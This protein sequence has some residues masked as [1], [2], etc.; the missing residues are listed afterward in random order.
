MSLR[1]A[2]I[3]ACLAGWTALSF[4]VVWYR[5]YSVALMARP[6]AFG[7]LLGGYLI[8]LALGSILAAKWCRAGWRKDRLQ[9]VVGWSLLASAVCGCLL[10]PA[11]AYLVVWTRHWELG[12]LLA[13][14]MALPFGLVMPLVAHASIEAGHEV[15]RRTAWIYGAN[16]FGAAAAPVIT[17][18][19]LLDLAGLV[20]LSLTL[21][22]VQSVVAAIVLSRSTARWWIGPAVCAMLVTAIWIGRPVLFDR[23]YERLTFRQEFSESTRFSEI[24]EN[25]S[26]VIG[27]LPTGAVYGAGVYDGMFNIDLHRAGENFIHRAYAVAAFHPAPRRVLMIG[28]SSGSWAAVIANHPAVE[29]LTIVEI[30]P[31]YIGLLDRHPPGDALRR[32]PRVQIAIDDGR[33]WLRRHEHEQFDL[34]VAN[35]TYHWRS[36][37]SSLLS[38]EFLDSIKRHLKPGGVYYF[39]ATSEPRVERT[40]AQA[41]PYAWRFYNMVVASESPIDVNL[42]RFARML[43]QYQ[44]YGRRMLEPDSPV[45]RAQRTLIVD[46]IAADLESRDAILTRTEG[47]EPI[48]DDNMGTEWRLPDRYARLFR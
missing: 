30:N 22:L 36:N 44:V 23:V 2:A 7:V 32:D 26:G 1:R 41:F 43:D 17:G 33:H 35:T 21:C 25:R 9:G 18:F 15:G 10:V 20:T 46:D 13:T 5:A 19:V 31:G 8:G 14:A 29:S 40:A 34:I 38:T 48:T 24:V 11:L 3:I 47:L 6:H 28:L 42:E 4:E 27:V 39:N 16:V 37:A 12:V 45:D